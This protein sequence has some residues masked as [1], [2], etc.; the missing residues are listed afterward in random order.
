MQRPMLFPE[1]LPTSYLALDCARAIAE[2]THDGQLDKQSRPII[3]HIIRVYNRCVTAGLDQDQLLAAI[4]HESLENAADKIDIHTITLL[5][6][7]PVRDLILSLTRRSGIE[8]Y[9][10]YIQRVS[11][12]PRAI[13]IKLADIE[14]NLDESRGPIPASLRARYLEARRVLTNAFPPQEVSALQAI[15]GDGK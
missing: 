5:F 7:P 15:R 13:P 12:N 10:Q 9:R 4:L 1:S 14:D 3:Y 8:T 2:Y 6:G 11:L